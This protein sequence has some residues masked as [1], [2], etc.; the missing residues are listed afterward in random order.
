M[1]Y[2]DIKKLI[3]PTKV[4][5]GHVQIIDQAAIVVENGMFIWIGKNEELPDEFSHHEKISC[6][7]TIVTPGLI[8]CHTHLIFSGDRSQEFGERLKGATYKDIAEK[9]GGIVTTVNAT[10][11]SSQQELLRL[12]RP[13][14]QRFIEQGV[15]TLEIKS[16]YGLTTE[17]EIT[18]LKVIQQLK[19][20]APIEI[21]STFL[22]AHDIPIEFRNQKD[23]YIKMVTE[24]MIP[25]I[26][27]NKLADAVDVF[28]E[29]GV[30]SV[31]ESRHIL[32][33]AKSF[34]LK[35]KVHA[36]E[37]TPLGGAELA[38][39]MGALSADHLLC[40]TE[41]GIQALKNSET[42]A[43]LLPGTAF[44][45]K[46]PYAPARKLIESGITVAVASDFNPG[47]CTMD[48]FSQHFLLATLYM[49]L[50]PNE[51][52]SAVTINAAKALGLEHHY[53]KIAIG[54][55]ANFVTWNA[56]SWEHLIYHASSNHVD[57]VY[58]NGQ[59]IYANEKVHECLY[60]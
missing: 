7:Q 56:P 8:D 5:N 60:L 27:K 43:V 52:L 13:R 2:T 49:G 58:A 22:G 59:L 9:G 39:E 17:S 19:N 20:E 24:E 25:I 42:V 55:S 41:H 37:L 14:V 44:F 50:T 45:I 18:Q 21:Q 4:G 15:T 57:K 10:R 33:V 53:G 30:Y 35:V 1:I 28:C 54:F 34:G 46:M 31:E 3:T 36:D 47:S 16:G 48:A 6:A 51:L 26:A 11:K 29:T 32:S 12:A 40:I 23:F 38:V